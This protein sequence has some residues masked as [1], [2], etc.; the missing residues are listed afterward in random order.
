MNAYQKCVLLVDLIVGYNGNTMGITFLGNVTNN[1]G[2]IGFSKNFAKSKT[3][4]GVS[5]KIGVPPKTLDGF[6]HGKNP[7]LK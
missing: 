5:I 1:M 4:L 3:I 2:F 7:H 6:F